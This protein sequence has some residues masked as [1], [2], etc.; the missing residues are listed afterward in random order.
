MKVCYFK[1]I[2]NLPFS[3][4]LTFLN[5][6][7]IKETV[8]KLNFTLTLLSSWVITCFSFGQPRLKCIRFV[9]LFD[10]KLSFLS[11]N[12]IHRINQLQTQG[13]FLWN[14]TT[15]DESCQISKGFKKVSKSLKKVSKGLKKSKWS[16]VWGWEK[17][18]LV[19]KCPVS[20]FLPH[21]LLISVYGC[22]FKGRKNYRIVFLFFFE[23]VFTCFQYSYKHILHFGNCFI[24]SFASL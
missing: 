8:V 14:W 19:K 9:N 6:V 17:H 23:N 4:A 11:Q 18:F 10:L 7:I 1:D 3:F 5:R 13:L 22:N 2:W 21:S 24:L 20:I 16:W 15:G 12:R